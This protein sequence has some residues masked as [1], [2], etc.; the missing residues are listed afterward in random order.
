MQG[1]DI[2]MINDLVGILGMI[3]HHLNL[4]AVQ[5]NLIQSAAV[6]LGEIGH[7]KIT[8]QNFGLAQESGLDDFV[9]FQLLL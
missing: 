6:G 8:F 5:G 1:F 9:I 7:F 2:A 4:T 3:G